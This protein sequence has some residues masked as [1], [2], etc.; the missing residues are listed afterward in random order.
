M[1]LPLPRTHTLIQ[2]LGQVSAHTIKIIVLIDLSKE[3]QLDV[4][5]SR[6]LLTRPNKD[7]LHPDLITFV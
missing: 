5:S 6:P 2:P 4:Q 3:S 7:E 1:G